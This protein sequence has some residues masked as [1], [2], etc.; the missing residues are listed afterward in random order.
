MHEEKPMTFPVVP[1]SVDGTLLGV[2][3]DLSDSMRTNIRNDNRSHISRIES[4]SQ[5]FHHV[6]EDADILINNM[7]MSEEISMRMFVY[8]FGFHSEGSPTWTD[9]IGDV[10]SIISNFDEEVNRYK[11]LQ[12]EVECVWFN[13]VEQ[14]LQQGQ[15]EGN[16]K[17][18]LRFFVKEELREQAIQAEQ[19]RN[20]AKFQLWCTS[21]CQR[22]DTYSTRIRAQVVQHKRVAFILIP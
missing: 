12:P 13:E 7:E 21:V 15:V 10:F 2:V 6:M 18:E 3:L 17:E 11:P 4:L 20:I 1:T 9:P 19:Q 22:I 5:E 14:I 16:A 8:G